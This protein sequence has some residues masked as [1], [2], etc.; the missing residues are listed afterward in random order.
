MN[1]WSTKLRKGAMVLAILASS[2]C[3]VAYAADPHGDV[4]IRNTGAAAP[5]VRPPSASALTTPSQK[6]DFHYGSSPIQKWFAQLD[7]QVYLHRATPDE[8][9]ILGRNFGSPPQLERVIEW[10]NTAARLAKK[11]RSLAKTLRSMSPPGSSGSDS[12]APSAVSAYKQALADYYDDSAS[13][14][15]E[16]IKPRPAA[17]TQEELEDQLKRVGER[18]ETVKITSTHLTEM[19]SSLRSQFRVPTA[20][21]DNK[22][23]TYVKK[24]P[25]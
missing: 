1:G 21:F 15:E 5:T 24:K 12:G 17:R 9:L 20:D 3:N 13:V 10:T 14:L 23:M 22:L 16:Y 11:F 7:E 19:D 8:K 18:S 25:H 6:Y 4:F 2:I